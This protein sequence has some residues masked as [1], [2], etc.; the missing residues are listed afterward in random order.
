MIRSKKILSRRMD[1]DRVGIIF[2]N[3]HK[4][5][6]GICSYFFKLIKFIKIEDGLGAVPL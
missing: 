4:I 1:P 6:P 3:H 5:R 2:P